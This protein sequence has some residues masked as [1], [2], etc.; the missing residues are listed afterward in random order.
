MLKPG[1]LIYVDQY[2][3]CLEGHIFDNKERSITLQG[4]WGGTL[5]CDA[6]SNYIYIH[7]QVSLSVLETVNAKLEFE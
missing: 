7:H 2:K 4:Y 1:D 5:F 3:S 6:A